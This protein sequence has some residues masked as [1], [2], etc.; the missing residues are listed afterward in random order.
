MSSGPSDNF[1]FR[2]VSGRDE[3]K[4]HRGVPEC[5]H[6]IRVGPRRGWSPR[7]RYGP[8]EEDEE[9]AGRAGVLGT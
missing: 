2:V 6:V 5:L 8:A 3:S 7:V 4:S 1:R 9:G